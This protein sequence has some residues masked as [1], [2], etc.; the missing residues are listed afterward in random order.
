M[1]CVH[2]TFPGEGFIK[3]N[4]RC[5]GVYENKDLLSRGVEGCALKTGAS[6]VL[7]AELLVELTDRG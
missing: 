6:S 7:R 1:I 3:Y 4:N 2:T 5:S